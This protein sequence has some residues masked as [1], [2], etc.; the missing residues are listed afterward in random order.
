MIQLVEPH[1]DNTKIEIR[2]RTPRHQ[3]GRRYGKGCFIH[4]EIN[5]LLARAGPQIRA[6][7]FN[8]RNLVI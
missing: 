7:I 6:N 3:A 5:E 1:L 8:C 4:L 2:V